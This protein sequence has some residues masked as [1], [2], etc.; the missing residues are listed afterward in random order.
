MASSACLPTSGARALIADAE[1]KLSAA[2]VPGAQFDAE[3]LLAHV[4]GLTRPQLVA[5]LAD[6]TITA[7]Q[8]EEF[9]KSVA[10]RTAREPLA[11]VTGSKGF[12]N[13]ELGVD[14]RVL[15]PRPETELLV[16]TAI[17]DRPCG[18][19]DVGTGSGAVALALASELPDGTV[20]A[21]DIST[22]AL[23]VAAAN[24]Q[25]LGLEARTRFFQ[26]DLLASV[27][28]VYD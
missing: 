19:L 14:A 26:S 10:R 27:D 9:Q 25:R 28:G 22:D 17:V 12:R 21:V 7:A 24:A 6:Q 13:I 8:L 23:E 20:D 16:A 2:G 4:L 11:Y 15:V 5:A 3:L 18:V 1:A